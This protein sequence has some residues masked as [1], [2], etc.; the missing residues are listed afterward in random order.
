[1]AASPYFF[2][3]RRSL[4]FGGPGIVEIMLAFVLTR[5]DVPFAPAAAGV[6][7]HRHF[8]FWAR[9][10]SPWRSSCPSCTASNGRCA[11]AR[12]ETPSVD[13]GTGP[14]EPGRYPS[15]EGEGANR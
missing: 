7:A 5:R 12:A 10:P 3:T 1:M 2:G 6:V 4:P 13:Y 9:T 14:S 8:N 11:L 15:Q